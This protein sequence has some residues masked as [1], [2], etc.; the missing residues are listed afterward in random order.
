MTAT[1]LLYNCLRLLGADVGYYVPNRLDE[2]Y[3]LNDEALRQLADRGASMVIS[4]D[5]GITSVAQARTA[6]EV[7]LELI[8]TDHH[9]LAESRAG[10]GGHCPSA[11][12]GIALSVWRTVRGG[13]R[14]QA[15]VGSVPAGQ[16]SQK[17][18]PHMRDFLLTAMGLAALGTVADVVP[19]IDENRI[20]VR[21]GLTSLHQSSLAGLAALLDVTKLK[22]KARLTSEDVGF[23]I[24][25]RLNAAGRLGQAQLGVELLTT[26]SPERARR[27]PSIFI[28]STTAARVWSGAFIWP[29]ARWPRSSSIRRTNRRWSWPVPAGTRA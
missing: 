3:G 29:R 27:W 28:N 7:G 1:G 15:G 20:L 2:G 22:Q 26:Q 6:R 21:H 23:T 18:S 5:C 19:L 25:P 8:I 14:F 11:A 17:V 16:Q 9:E 4:V 24:A 10:R 13:D 12:A